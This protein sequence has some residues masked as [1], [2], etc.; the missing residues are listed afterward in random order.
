MTDPLQKSLPISPWSDPRLARM[1]G[2]L[3]LDPAEWILIDDAY[4]GQMALRDE[5]IKGRPEDVLLIDLSAAEAASELLSFVLTSIAALP[6]FQVGQESVRRPDGGLVT[7]DRADP[8]ATAGRLVQEDLCI[9]QPRGAEHVLTAAVLCFPAS[10]TLAEKFL[11]PLIGIHGP[12]AAYDDDIARRVQRLFDAIRPERPMWRAN[13]H[14]WKEARL[15]A[16]RTEADPRPPVSWPA[17]Y[18]RSERQC[19]SRLPRTGAVVFSIHT[20]LLRT[21]NLTPDQVASLSR[22]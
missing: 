12:I 6:G 8:L 4:A 7:L 16:P 20:F 13:A 15:F 9:M 11:R 3:P 21:D 19:L 10:W 1:P 17:P 2:I 14:L 18:L 22:R 5:L